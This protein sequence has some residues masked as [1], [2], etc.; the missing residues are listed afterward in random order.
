LLADRAGEWVQP[1]AG[2]S[3]KYDSLVSC[4]VHV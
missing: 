2:P 4:V 1:R 3:R